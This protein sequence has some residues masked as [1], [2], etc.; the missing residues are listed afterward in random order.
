MTPVHALDIHLLVRSRL[1]VICIFLC[2]FSV[3]LSSLQLNILQTVLGASHQNIISICT[4][5][6]LDLFQCCDVTHTNIH[7]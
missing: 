4:T 2:L 7:W 1:A 3:L 6:E 5:A